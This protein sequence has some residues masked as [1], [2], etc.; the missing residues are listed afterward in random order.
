M[1]RYKNPLRYLVIAALVTFSAT[2]ALAQDAQDWEEQD[3][4]LVGRITHLE[5]TL[6]RYADDQD[7]WV[8]TAQDAPVGTQDRLYTAAESRAEIILP[9]NT[10]IRMDG[11]T[12]IQI[13]TLGANFTEMD[14]SVGTVRLYNK[15]STAEIKTTTPFGHIIT[16]AGAAVDLS[17]Y[18]D[19]VMV[20]ALK[21]QAYFVHNPSATRHEVQAGAGAI[22]ADTQQVSAEQGDMAPAWGQWNQQMDAL[23]AMRTRTIGE[24]AAYLPPELQNDAY[25]LDTNGRWE[26]VYYEGGHYRFWRPVHVHAG[27]TPFSSGVWSMW[28]GDQVWIPHEP[29]GY[30]T[31]H[32][33]NWI[34]TA[35]YWYWAP[36]VTRIMLQAGLPLFHIGFG[37]YPGRVA[38]I[39]TT[40]YVGWFPLAPYEPYFSHRRWGRRSMVVANGANFRY[41]NHTYKHRRH[42]VVIH[43]SHFNQGQNY[44]DVRV[45]PIAYATVAKRFQTTPV[46]DKRTF[47]DSR[48]TPAKNRPGRKAELRKPLSIHI[49]NS[50][51]K[52]AATRKAVQYQHR[53]N[54]SKRPQIAS[55]TPQKRVERKKQTKQGRPATQPEPTPIRVKQK[56]RVQEQRLVRTHSPAPEQAKQSKPPRRT[57]EVKKADPKPGHARISQPH[58]K[59]RSDAGQP[60]TKAIANKSAQKKELRRR[61]DQQPTASG[62][63]TQADDN[64]PLQPEKSATGQDRPIQR[65]TQGQELRTKG[66]T[67][68][69]SRGSR[70][71]GFMPGRQNDSKS[72]RQ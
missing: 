36:P 49:K 22:F 42:A 38:W 65:Q 61:S 32:Y 50:R 39:H 12:E 63:Q 19:G 30:V 23:W 44:R 51:P 41:N 16:P 1:T 11:D 7:D 69:N 37:W 59:S 48:P 40:A 29:F 10:W 8:D 6:S 20:T 31:H 15:S 66:H 46:L 64:R 25:A 27:W 33:G 5:G 3:T 54:L 9:N 45:Q 70:S 55:G 18:D 26:Q 2:V 68:S 35:G 67:S 62:Q 60:P 14:I 43:R 71:A 47:N 58:K 17:V 53:D 72:K 13:V 4:T 34:F 24:S 56:N 57:Q 52:R 28:W 21:N